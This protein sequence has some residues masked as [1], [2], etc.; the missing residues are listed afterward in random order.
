MPYIGVGTENSGA[1]E[2]YYE[3]HG[4]GPPVVLIHGYPLSGR[5]WD[6]QAVRES[7]PSGPLETLRQTAAPVGRP[8]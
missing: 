3:D 6:R 1:I 8:L 5:A 7:A 2:L 4:A